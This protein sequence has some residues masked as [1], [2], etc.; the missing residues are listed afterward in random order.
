MVDGAPAVRELINRVLYGA[1]DY[2]LIAQQ[3]EVMMRDECTGQRMGV[4]MRLGILTVRGRAGEEGGAE[5]FVEGLHR[6]FVE[7][8]F[9]A[10]QVTIP[11]DESTFDAIEETYLR[12]YDFDAASFDGVISTK[13]PTYLVRH[14]NHVCYSSAHGARVLRY[15]RMPHF[16]SQ[17][18]N[19]LRNAPW[20]T[21]SIHWRS[22]S[23]ARGTCSRSAMRSRSGSPGVT[24]STRRY[25]I[26]RSASTDFM[27]VRTATTF[28]CPVGCTAGSALI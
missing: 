9:D 21:N 2:A 16:R 15:V 14:P 11:S 17:R 22:R 24:E 10:D 5:R 26:L 8:G 27:R 4:A 12:C 25:C 28:S 7:R 18:R 19:C 20:C 13:A 3:A 23:R 1:Q 6:A